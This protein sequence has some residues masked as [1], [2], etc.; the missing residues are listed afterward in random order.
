MKYR[1]DI[2]TWGTKSAVYES[3]SVEDVLAWFL[4]NWA[5]TYDIGNCA[6]NVFKDDVELSFEENNK[7]GFYG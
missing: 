2:W 3:D 5:H 7:L 6:F 1:I 4:N